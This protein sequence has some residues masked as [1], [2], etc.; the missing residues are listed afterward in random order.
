[1]A[2]RRK[3]VILGDGGVGKSALLRNY[4]GAEFS[5]Q[6]L[7]TTDG[8]VV[9]HQE[10]VRE[11]TVQLQLWDTAG[12]TSEEELKLLKIDC[13]QADACLLVYDVTR[14]L[15]F[16][17]LELFLS[18]FGTCVAPN[19]PVVVVGTKQDLAKEDTNQCEAM[20]RWCAS[21]GIQAHWLVSAKTTIPAQPVSGFT[22]SGPISTMMV[23]LLEQLIPREDNESKLIYCDEL[24]C[25]LLW[26]CEEHSEQS[27]ILNAH[28]EP[29]INGDV[30][31]L[32]YLDHVTFSLANRSFRIHQDRKIAETGG[33][34]WDA[35][36]ILAEYLSLHPELVSGRRCLELGAGLGLAGIVA[37]SL[38]G[39]VAITDVQDYLPILRENAAANPPPP[40]GGG[41]ISVTE[42]QWGKLTKELED[43]LPFEVVFGS[44]IIYNPD[45]LDDLLAS[46]SQLGSTDTVI[47]LAHK[48]R[49]K[50]IEDHFFAKCE[51]HGF[52]VRR[53][54]AAGC[55]NYKP[56]EQV[57]IVRL[58]RAKQADK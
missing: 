23:C 40:E 4:L 15:S 7:P 13:N 31:G 18:V 2:Q 48:T 38:G 46:F 28:Y 12:G 8:E 24:S 39:R 30:F 58:H 17:S 1:M 19:T 26:P 3:I 51:E 22:R 10:R 35:S 49:F 55:V 5:N 27:P 16:P 32:E 9:F 44:D 34:V 33:M 6:Y 37:A 54:H 56:K 53:I 43:K 14:P 45:F 50:P 52:V 11:Q 20:E 47:Y 21:R 29:L 25:A 36:I 57:R 41:E 42:Y